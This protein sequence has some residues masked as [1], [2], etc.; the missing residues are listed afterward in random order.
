MKCSV[1]EW[2]RRGGSQ[3]KTDIDSLVF[4][5]RQYDSHGGPRCSFR[6][7][8]ISLG[9]GPVHIHGGH[10]FSPRQSDRVVLETE[11]PKLAQTEPSSPR[12]RTNMSHTSSLGSFS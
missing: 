9:L 8:K 7:F 11:I 12:L 1:D 5:G 10:P 4:R 2:T 6:A 3:M